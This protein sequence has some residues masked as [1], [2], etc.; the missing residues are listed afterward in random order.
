MGERHLNREKA[1]GPGRVRGLG[2]AVPESCFVCGLVEGRGGRWK[3]W[4]AGSSTPSSSSSRQRAAAAAAARRRHPEK[5]HK[6]TNRLSGFSTPNGK[7]TFSGVCDGDSTVNEH[8][9]T[10]YRNQSP[11]RLIPKKAWYSTFD[12]SVFFAQICA[13]SLGELVA[14]FVTIFQQRKPE[15]VDPG[16]QCD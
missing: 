2:A 14:Y 10:P 3:W 13:K 5:S 12:F 15:R 11:L 1:A 7:S 8:R 9:G 6:I 16:T 4:R